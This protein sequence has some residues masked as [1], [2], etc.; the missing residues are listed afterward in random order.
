MKKISKWQKK[1]STKHCHH[2]TNKVICLDH[3]Q[4]FGPLTCGSIGFGMTI[5]IR[6][7]YKT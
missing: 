7:D 3:A 2:Q 5:T 6:I 4:H 1:F